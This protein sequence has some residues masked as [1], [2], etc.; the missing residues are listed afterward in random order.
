MKTAAGNQ[1]GFS[2]LVIII[3]AA[4]TVL[5]LLAGMAVALR[6]SSKKPA[7]T[8]TQ[9]T[10]DSQTI[11]AKW[12]TALRPVWTADGKGSW[13][14][15]PY[16]VA[17]ASCPDPLVFNTPTPQL[18][19]ATAVWYPGQTR[20]TTGATTP[21]YASYGGLRFDKSKN[22]DITVTMPFNGYVYRGGQYLVGNEVQYAFDIANACGVMIHLDHLHTLS[23]NLQAVADTLPAAAAG[24][25][26][27]TAIT[28]VV[29]F[30]SGDVLATAVGLQNTTPRTVSFDFGIY[31]LRR[32]TKLAGTSAYRTA[33]AAAADAEYSY[34]GLCW[35]NLFDNPNDTILH[36]LPAADTTAGKQS[37]YCK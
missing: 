36:R 27:T 19:K 21:V 2:H 14:S 4:V 32:P 12:S 24:N 9:T 37:D 18:S 31:D 13:L 3:A 34:Y 10:D 35:L 11:A 26:K 33:H 15:I 1:K 22:T 20:L 30:N 5:I 16:N 7:A 29:G 17:P 8:A 23:P 25:S 28:P 6:Q